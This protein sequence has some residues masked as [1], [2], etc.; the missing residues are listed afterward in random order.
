M[1]LHFDVQIHSSDSGY[2]QHS[3]AQ[4]LPD[5]WEVLCKEALFCIAYAIKEEDI[6]ASLYV[7]T[8]QTQCGT[9]QVLIISEDKKHVFTAVVSITCS[10]TMLPLQIIYKGA[11]M[12]SCP[13]L[14]ALHYD[15]CISEGF[16]FKFLKTNTY[17]STHETME[18]L[19]D[20]II[21]PYF[22]QV[23]AALGLPPLQ[24]AIWQIDMWSVHCSAKF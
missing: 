12:K 24:K 5:N 22:E 8:D 17:W 19:V 7:N 9:K 16:C 15:N 10:G 3:T 6:L 23:K 11:M 2:A 20:N 4:K 18:S 13:H 21:A 14:T 1:A